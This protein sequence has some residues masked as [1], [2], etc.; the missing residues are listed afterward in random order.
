MV[1]SQSNSAP[2][3]PTSSQNNN[4]KKS[5]NWNG[6]RPR[7]PCQIC[8]YR[9]H[10]ALIVVVVDILI[11]TL[12]TKMQLLM[13]ITLQLVILKIIVQVLKFLLPTTLMEGL[14][15]DGVYT[16]RPNV[17]QAFTPEAPTMDEWHATLGHPQRRILSSLIK[18]FHLPCSTSQ[19]PKDYSNFPWLHIKSVPPSSTSSVRNSAQ[20][21]VASSTSTSP[22]QIHP[23]QLRS[24]TM[25][26][27]HACLST[28]AKNYLITEPQTFTQAKPYAEWKTN[29]KI[30]RFKARLVAK[31]Y[32]QQPG[33][34]Y[35]ETFSPMIFIWSSS[36]AFKTLHIQTMCDLGFQA[37]KANSSFFIL[38]QGALKFYVLIY[39]DDI[40]LTCSDSTKLDWFLS[41][42][43]STFPVRDLGS[44]HFFL[45]IE[46]QF[47]ADG[48]LITQQKPDISFS[49]NTL[50][51]F[52]HQPT[53]E[54]WTIAKRLLRYL[55]ATVGF[56]LFFSK[57]STLDLQCFTD[58]DWGG[59]PNDR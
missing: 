46:A 14:S 47:S 11:T 23:T 5:S 19:A 16:F 39:V 34:D 42:I 29:G 33:I 17:K 20:L 25:Q 32:L 44:L 45:G 24:S 55:K 54:H 52:M 30:D 4:H 18:Q 59:C 36:L 35:T 48:L 27:R 50:S 51:Q 15:E 1:A 43:K 58:S 13:L 9:N 57:H 56:G 3:L 31:G 7:G 26:K 28:K 2:L 12:T 38:H 49:V 6:N 37:S 53:Q 10:T 22:P 40:V 21:N 8:G 41:K